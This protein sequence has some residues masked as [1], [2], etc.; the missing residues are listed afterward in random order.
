MPDSLIEMLSSSE[1]TETAVRS[2]TDEN[3]KRMTQVSAVL[4]KTL[5]DEAIRRGLWDELT[6]TIK[7][8][9]KA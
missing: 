4:F 8:P 2:L 1:W 5:K 3:L 7:L 9:V 6:R